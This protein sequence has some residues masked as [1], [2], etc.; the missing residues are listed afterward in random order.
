MDCLKCGSPIPE[1][2]GPGRPRKFC[3]DVCKRAAE[4][5]MRRLDSRIA[6]LER[7]ESTYRIKNAIG[8]AKGAAEEIKRLEA[9]LEQLLAAGEVR[10]HE[11]E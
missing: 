10:A 11:S 5:E 2:E 1:H 8:W 7:D 4:M 3:S 6:K 9:R